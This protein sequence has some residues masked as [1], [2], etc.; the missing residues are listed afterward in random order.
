M[1]VAARALVP[2]HVLMTIAVGGGIVIRKRTRDM[3]VYRR[4]HQNFGKLG[5]AAIVVA[6]AIA[7]EHIVGFA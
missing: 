4:I 5:R 6:V 7:F 2:R 3:L 1:H